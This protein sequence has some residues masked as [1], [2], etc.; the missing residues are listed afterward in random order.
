MKAAQL[1]K[2]DTSTVWYVQAGIEQKWNSLGKTNIFAEYRQD[3]VGLSKAADS[4]GLQ[5]WAAGIAQ[6][7]ENADMT[8]YAVYRHFDGDFAKTGT[9]TDLDALD[10]LITGAKINF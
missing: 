1:G 9:S 4:S 2:D 8:L 5:F 10:M 7:I 6:N 3:D